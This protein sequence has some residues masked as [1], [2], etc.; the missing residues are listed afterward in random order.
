MNHCFLKPFVGVLLTACSWAGDPVEV[1]TPD[2]R[3]AVQPQLSVAPSGKTSVVFGKG[4]A[5]YFTAD[6]GALQ[7]S[8]P[9]KVGELEKLALKM[10]RGPRV[11]TT[12]RLI[13][14]T[15]I[16]HADGNVHA[17]TSSD[18]GKSFVSRPALNTVAGSAREGM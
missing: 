4:N 16:S 14:V 12:D 2:L 17:W 7:F 3:G 15:A 1:T 9:V 8:T 11:A 18:G 5:I 13:L 6:N 10:R